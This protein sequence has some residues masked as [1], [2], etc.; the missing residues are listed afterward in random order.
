MNGNRFS[1]RVFI[2]GSAAL[3]AGLSS[4]LSLA[5]DEGPTALTIVQ[6]GDM[7]RS[8]DLS[9]V[10]L[11]ESYLAR[12]ERLQPLTNAYITVTASQALEQARTLDRELSQGRWRGPLHG[13]PVGFKDNIDTAGVPTTA[14]SELFANRLPEQDA[15]VVTRLNNAGAI[16]LGKLNMHEFAFG[17]TSA[18]T[19]YGPVHNPWN[20]DHVPGGSSGGSA[21][22]VS[23]QMCAAALGTDTAASV[24]MPAAFCGIVGLKATYGLVSIRGII[25]LAESLDHAGP[26][27]RTVGDSAL[28]LQA[29]AGYDPLDVASIDA[30]LPDYSGSL[31]LPVQGLRLGI[32]RATL[33]RRPGYRDRNCHRRGHIRFG[34]YDR[35]D[36]RCG[37]A[38]DAT[39]SSHR[40]RGLRLSRRVSRGRGQ[41]RALST[42]YAGTN[43]GRCEH[44]TDGIPAGTARTGSV[45]EGNCEGI[46]RSR[47]AHHPD[48]PGPAAHHRGGG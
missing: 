43:H 12:I 4:R 48:D 39:F 9:A 5:Q 38:A 28:L 40:R 20:L 34:Q 44:A 45:Q 27:C 31:D 24:R 17:G 33:L 7:I 41:P 42:R 15:E 16:T 18:V 30:P 25:P 46:R 6:A 37:A 2:G 10:E 8:G 36:Q 22:A 32:P 21:A 19:H 3:A 23:A 14:A 47:P 13:I 29:L 1:R 35:R 26:M 11:V